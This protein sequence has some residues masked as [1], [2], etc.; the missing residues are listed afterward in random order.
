MA[1]L[2]DHLGR[3]TYKEY[4]CIMLL[5]ITTINNLSGAVNHEAKLSGALISFRI[6]AAHSA[7]I[8]TIPR[9]EELICYF[10]KRSSL[11]L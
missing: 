9:A 5:E 2:L 3:K 8:T 7:N 4:S 6:V 11:I 1:G 10:Q